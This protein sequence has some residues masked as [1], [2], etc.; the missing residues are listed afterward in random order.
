MRRKCRKTHMV[1]SIS[2]RGN[3][4]IL[5]ECVYPL[6]VYHLGET[7]IT[8]YNHAL[9]NNPIVLQVEKTT[10]SFPDFTRHFFD[11]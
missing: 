7:I 6:V 8:L 5:R 3:L 11:S 1:N 4:H 2:K 9:F 10:L